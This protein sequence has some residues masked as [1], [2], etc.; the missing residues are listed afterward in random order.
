MLV[1]RYGEEIHLSHYKVTPKPLLEDQEEQPNNRPT[2]I[3]VHTNNGSRME[4]IP[5]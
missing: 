1:S 5:S 4:G 3:Y 2:I